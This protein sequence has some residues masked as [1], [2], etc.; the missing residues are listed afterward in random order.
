M[1]PGFG[2]SS[3][4]KGS[5]IWK[6]EGEL[7]NGERHGKGRLTTED[8]TY[9][10]GNWIHGK[11]TG[12]G[13][14]GDSNGCIREGF[15][16]DG[17]YK[18]KIDIVDENGRHKQMHSYDE[19]K[20]YNVFIIY[21][22]VTY[23]GMWCNGMKNGYGE[24][25]SREEGSHK[26]FFLNDH[27]IGN[28]YRLDEYSRYKDKSGIPLRLEAKDG[29]FSGRVRIEYPN[30]DVYEG[31]WKNGLREGAGTYTYANGDVYF[32][33]WISN[34]KNSLNASYTCKGHYR[35]C[36]PFKDDKF[37]GYAKMKLDSGMEFEGYFKDGL[38]EGEGQCEYKD[39]ICS[40]NWI[41]NEMDGEFEFRMKDGDVLTAKMS[42]DEFIEGEYTSSDGGSVIIKMNDGCLQ[43]PLYGDDKG[44]LDRI[45]RHIDDGSLWIFDWDASIILSVE[46]HKSIK[47]GKR[48]TKD[49][50]KGWDYTLPQHEYVYST[51]KSFEDERTIREYDWMINDYN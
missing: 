30:G 17:I 4:S 3:T 6:Y 46:R 33:S 16:I 28:V 12:L 35:Y 9:Y 23:N 7:R 21:G 19:N 11:F 13:K 26:G 1:K 25:Q 41:R 39:C 45:I 10:E 51:R 37:D 29:K 18:G 14:T 31:G 32:G 36:G 2:H 50:F 22:N 38:R 5:K 27:F 24:T 48:K 20:V 34:R 44:A 47:P 40:G 43:T 15:F 42:G 8:G 49:P